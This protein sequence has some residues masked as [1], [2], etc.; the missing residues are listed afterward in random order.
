MSYKSNQVKSSKQAH[1]TKGGE[2][3]LKG[4]R[5]FSVSVAS[6]SSDSDSDRSV[7]STEAAM[8]YL[9][10]VRK[11]TQSLPKVVVADVTNISTHH[12]S[13][14]RGSL[15]SVPSLVP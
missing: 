14:P 15:G 10:S 11:Q 6:S 8:K 1:E 3:E 7:S 4:P 13:G 5:M 12:A 9:A 2:I